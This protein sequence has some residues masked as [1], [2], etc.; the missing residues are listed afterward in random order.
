MQ[1]TSRFRALAP[2]GVPFSTGDLLASLGAVAGFSD[3]CRRLESLL[4]AFFDS[5]HCFLLHSGR[6]A[7]TVLFRALRRL[8][9][10]RNEVLLPAYTCYSVPAAAVRAGL[11]VALCDVDE[12][13]LAIRIDSLLDAIS[14]RTLCVVVTHLYGIPGNVESVTAAAG[15]RGVFTVDDAAQAM[16]AEIRGR[17][18][19]TCGDAGIFSLGRGKALPAVRGGGILTDKD[20][21]QEA[22]CREM[23]TR[24]SRGSALRTPL[25]AILLSL[26]LRPRM[27]WIARLLPFLHLGESLYSTSFPLRLLHGTQAALGI[28]MLPRL[29]S[30]NEERVRRALALRRGLEGDTAGLRFPSI[31][32]DA[33]PIYS[34]LPVQ[35]QAPLPGSLGRLGV[36]RSYP[37]PLSDVPGVQPHLVSRNTSLP[38]STRLAR[39]TWTLPTHPLV[40]DSDV[41]DIIQI[42]RGMGKLHSEARGAP[43]CVPVGL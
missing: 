1:T 8:S 14:R 34:R 24:R 39:T 4:C 10:E 20:R 21:I 11:H 5:R 22:I 9:P 36:V 38:G 26:L 30:L 2:A 23:P 16:G 28:R 29:Q 13:T 17:R 31:A 7:L 43:G 40:R 33:R 6:A 27:Y 3:P 18:L 41:R 19:G 37:A 12:E 25:E 32:E 15:R 42:I 35:C